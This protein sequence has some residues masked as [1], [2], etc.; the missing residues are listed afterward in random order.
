VRDTTPNSEKSDIA[1]FWP[2]N[3]SNWNLTARLIVADR[4]LNRWQHARL[5]ALLNITQADTLIANQTWKY[6]YNF[7]HPMTAIR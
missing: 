3:G 2:K 1:R 5:L 4:N 7:W 6:T